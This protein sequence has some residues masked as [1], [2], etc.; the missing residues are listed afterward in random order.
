MP[1]PL[2]HRPGHRRTQPCQRVPRTGE[3][4][5]VVPHGAV[6]VL[7]NQKTLLP[8]GNVARQCAVGKSEPA[9]RCG[10]VKRVWFRQ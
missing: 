5:Q 3:G 2:L 10:F 4:K 9:P 6:L 1:K 7:L 8:T